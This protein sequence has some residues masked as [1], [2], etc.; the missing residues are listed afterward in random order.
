[1]QNGSKLGHSKYR[2]NGPAKDHLK[3]GRQIWQFAKHT[4][5]NMTYRKTL[6]KSC[7]TKAPS[8]IYGPLGPIFY[9]IDEANIMS[10]CLENQFRAHDLLLWP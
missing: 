10:D 5:S 7:G 6:I 8:A 2:E 3:D 4:S 9:P 1:M